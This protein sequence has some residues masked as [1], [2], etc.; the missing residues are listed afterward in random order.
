MVQPLVGED[1]AAGARGQPG[2]VEHLHGVLPG[3]AAAGISLRPYVEHTVCRK[4]WQRPVHAGVLI[5][6]SV[7]LP[8]PTEIGEPADADPRLWLLWALARTS[9]CRSSRFRQP[10]R[11]CSNGSRARRIPTPEIRIFCTPRA[12]PEACWGCWDICSSN[13]SPRGAVRCSAG[14]WASGLSPRSLGRWDRGSRRTRREGRARGEANPNPEPS[15]PNPAPSTPNPA[16][17]TQHPEPLPVDR[18]VTG[19]V[20]LAARRDTAPRHRRRVGSVVWVVPLALY[21]ATFIAAFSTR[22]FGSARR[23]G[24]VGASGRCCIVLVFARGGALPDSADRAR[25]SRRR[26]RCWRCC[27]TRAWLKLRPDPARLPGTSCA[28]RSAASSAAQPRPRRPAR[29]LVDSR[30]SPRDRRGASPSPADRP[31]RPHGELARRPLGVA[32]RRGRAVRR[33]ILV[34]LTRFNDEREPL[35]HRASASDVV[36]DPGHR[37]CCSH[38]GRRCSSP[39]QPQDCSSAQAVVRTGG[40]VLHRERT[41][42]GVHEVTSQQN[43]DWHVLT[44]GTTTHGVQAFRGKVRAPADGVLPSHRADRRCRLHA[45]CRRAVSR[46]GCVGLGAGALAGYA[47]NGTRMDFFEVDEAVIRIAE[48][49]RYFTYLAD[50]RARPGATVRT[51]AI[52]GR[53][54][55]A[56]CRRPR[57]ISSSSMRSRR[58]RSR[59]TSSRARPWRCSRRASNRAASWRSTC[60]A[61]F[62]IS[63]PCSRASPRIR[64]S[65]LHQERQ[66]RAARTGRGSHAAVRLGRSGAQRT[67]ISVRSR[68][69]L[70]DGFGSPATGARLWTDDYTNVLGALED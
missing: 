54:G 7:M 52:D 60:R 62:S 51:Q 34:R 2:R 33:R 39:G 16:P 41:F 67:A 45:L 26:S 21:L 15:N 3:R 18:L 35:D 68:D 28:S 37:C 40:E 44:H 50:A 24:T 22:G 14:R 57:T 63:A 70:R 10:P 27:A 11:F 56:P 61:G 58:T 19:A 17:S 66:G 1:P 55:C 36:R 48:N 42:F 6:A 5:V 12:T 32:C 23:W 25:A 30:V 8:L 69:R 43:G 49:P 64:A 59:R 4:R 13:R 47:G 29:V 20:G 46:R 65:V 9:A 31:G 53:L 38:R